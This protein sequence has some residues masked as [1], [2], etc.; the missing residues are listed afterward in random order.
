MIS[1]HTSLSTHLSAAHIP[2]QHTSLST[3][4]SAAHISQQHTSPS[5]THLLAAHISQQHTSLSSTHPPAAHI[6]QQH[7]S[8]SST[9]LS[10]RDSNNVAHVPTTPLKLNISQYYQFHTYSVIQSPNVHQT[11][12]YPRQAFLTILPVMMAYYWQIPTI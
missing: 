2:Q 11:N 10:A 7:T 1:Q 4:L 6:P 9:H 5:S 12:T 8:P 3:H